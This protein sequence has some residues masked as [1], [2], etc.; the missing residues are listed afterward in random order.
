[1]SRLIAREKGSSGC[2]HA[3]SLE[4]PLEPLNCGIQFSG[5]NGLLMSL[6]EAGL[7]E[8]GNLFGARLHLGKVLS[9]LLKLFIREWVVLWHF[10]TSGGL[11]R[12]TASFGRLGCVFEAC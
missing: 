9:Y 7:H 1:M 11:P 8:M 10:Q 12:S 2:G 3:I 6:P 5:P 4:F